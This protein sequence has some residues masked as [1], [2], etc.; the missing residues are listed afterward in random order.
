MRNPRNHLILLGFICQGLAWD[1]YLLP[2]VNTL[3]WVLCLTLPKKAIQLG[4][5]LEAVG[6]LV[7]ILAGYVLSTA[8]GQDTHFS[9]GH[10]ITFIQAVRL[11]RPL[12]YREKVLSVL[13][14][15]F[16]LGVACTVIL[17][18]R[19]IL[20]FIAAVWLVPQAL[21]EVQSAHFELSSTPRTRPGLTV[22]I[23]IAASAVLFFLVFPRGIIG[24]PIQVNRGRSNDPGTLLD[25]VLDP[26]RSGT[27]QSSRVIFSVEGHNIGNLRCYALTEFDGVRWTGEEHSAW[28]P[29]DPT[30]PEKLATL[31]I[32]RVRAKSSAVFGHVLPTDGK[33]AEIHGTFFRSPFQNT[34]GIIECQNIWN[35]ANNTYEYRID[36]HPKPARIS[37]AMVERYTRYP[38]QSA[39]LQA[40]LDNVIGGSTAPTEQARKIEAYLRS[41]F[42]YRLGAPELNRF[43]PVDDFVFKQKEGHCERFA[44]TLALLLRMKNIPSKVVI[45]YLPTSRNWISGWVD[46]RFKDAHA[47]TEAY[48]KDL[49]WVQLDATPPSGRISSGFELGEFMEAIDTAWY[50]NVVNF[51]SAAQNQFFAVSMES[52]TGAVGALGSHIGIVLSGAITIVLVGWLLAKKGGRKNAETKDRTQIMAAHYY[53]QMLR[54]LAQKGI[55]RGPHLTPMEFLETIRATETS[56]APDVEKVTQFFCATRYGEE[57]ISPRQQEEIERALAQIRTAEPQTAPA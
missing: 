17:D 55:H 43:K 4:S 37:P 44:S 24:S 19:F 18:Y 38:A 30:E 22:Y 28:R 45:G 29:L 41:N 11:T 21:T 8:A 25:N 50:A 49:G 5:L 53:G 9:F 47:W 7:G 32:R 27:S 14:A 56:I 42:T 2:V 34:H 12:N 10:G 35:A 1:D 31:P 46:I 20:I 57:P 3:V 33:V 36:P 15:L 40:W 51:D 52:L 13:M 39:A 16:Q 48:F 26:T 23:T 6:V 54:A